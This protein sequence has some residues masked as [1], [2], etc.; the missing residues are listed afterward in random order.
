MAAVAVII[1]TFNQARFLG[2]AI[3][4]AL[5]QTRLPDEIIVVD[6]GSTDDPATVVAQF[7]N[8]RLIRQ[9]NRGLS[10]ARNTGLRNAA[11]SYVLFL[12]ADDRLMP[13]AVEA[14]LACIASRPDCAFVYGGF[15]P[16]SENGRIIG[17][18]YV[19]S[20]DGNAHLAF[21]RRGF[22]T[23]SMVLFRRDCL[24]EINGFDETLRRV[25]DRDL[26]LR[27]TQ[28][29]PIAGHKEI[30]TEYR[31]HGQNTSS[32]RVEQ[33]KALFQIFKQYEARN[34]P[35]PLT[36]S[37]LREGRALKRKEFASDMIRKA[38]SQWRARRPRTAMRSLAQSARWAP[39]FTGRALSA[40]VAR[41][42]SK[43][44]PRPAVRWIDS[45]RSEP[46]PIPIGSISF[47][48]LRRLSPISR[49]FGCGR[50]RPVDRYYIESFLAQ[51]ASDIRG[52]AL[53][54]AD[55][56]Y[57]VR[58]G[59]ERVTRS[60]VL[61]LVSGNP[62][63]TIVG[64]LATGEG[65]PRS[66]FD[67]IILTQTLLMIY[68]VKQAVIHLRDALRPGGVALVTVPGISQI[69]RYDM[70]RWGDYWRFT[71]VSARRLFSDVFGPENVTVV[72]YGNVLTSSAFLQGM[73]VQELRKEELDHYDEDY[74][75]I[76][77]IRAVKSMEP[78]E[79]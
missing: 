60:E 14:G 66:A 76:I 10:G 12:D 67:C 79:A 41:R 35:D 58:F 57:T 2:D 30:V 15:R 74:Q 22:S 42:A 3:N 63:A 71:D 11:A 26:Y 16:I 56:N 48:D 4:S 31:M 45:F 9:E 49:G 61:H 13:R 34:A 72:T 8:V 38:A 65:I 51:N 43:V 39:Y 70:D 19:D 47:G 37:A 33:L 62:A 78:Q 75:V 69:S 21:L 36:L 20:I 44:L 40:A 29:Y 68:E 59:G 46:Y 52:R 64:D 55:N 54:V 6:D 50:G 28:K 1:P 24:L 18:D 77:A 32:N 5:A 25:E 73:A 27:L 53:E 23:P 17:P 7:P